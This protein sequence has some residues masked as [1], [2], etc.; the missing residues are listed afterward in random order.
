MEMD[1]R[2][3]MQGAALSVGGLLMCSADVLTTA[4]PTAESP[5]RAAAEADAKH[6]FKVAGWDQRIQPTFAAAA[7]DEVLI[8]INQAWRTAW[9]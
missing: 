6:V 5:A 3:F 8:H 9:R 2:S 7:D 4:S 1:R